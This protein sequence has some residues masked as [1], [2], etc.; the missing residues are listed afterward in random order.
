[1]LTVYNCITN[2]HDLRLVGLAAVI[3]ALA[4]F[5]AISLLWHVRRS[6]GPMRAVWLGVSATS[7]GF[8]IWATHFIAMLAFAPGLPE[9]Y[10]IPLT[11]LSLVAAIVLT[12]AG[13]AVA[14]A[15]T[16]T[17]GLLLG[18]AIVGG[19]I[20]AMHYTGM[21]AFE[22]QG[23]VVWDPGLVTASII[24][25]GLFGAAAL[26]TG[27]RG[28]SL[29]WKGL[30]A[31][32]L[33]LAICSHHFTAMGAA[34]IIP[35]PTIEF[36]KAAIPSG[37]LAIAV[38][39]ASFIVIMLALAGAALDMRD[40]R[41]GELEV[42]R[43]RGLANAVVE[44]LLVCE[45]ETIVTVNDNFA[46]LIGS[47][48]ESLVGAKLEQYI[49]EESTR[50]QLSDDPEQPIEGEMRHADGT[51]TPVE[52]IVRSIDFAGKTHQAIAV[53]DLRARKQA[54]QHI[55]YLAHHDALTGLVNRNTFNK[56]LDQE[57]ESAL[58]TG[59]RV[60]VLC[61]DLDRFKEV[62]DLFGHA[63]G[64][65]VLQ[66][67]AKRITGVLDDRH[68][69]ARLS[70]DE[71]AIVAPRLANPAA[72]GRIAED[73][74]ECLRAESQNP[75]AEALVST[76]IGVAICP[77]DATDRQTLLTHADTALYRAKKDGRATYRFF[78]AT[79]GAEV[80]DRR[81]LE[82][83]LRHAIARDELRLVYQPQK[84]IRT[85]TVIGFE[86]L[87]RWKHPTRG[88]VPPAVF[89]PIAEE[90][91]SILS[92]GEWVLRT[93]C[94]DAARWTN[95]LTVAVNV[96][97]T[98]IHNANFAHVVHEILFETGMTPGRLELEITE[99]AL[100]RDLTRALSTL[101]RIK[102]LGVRIAMDDF[103]TGYSSLSNLRAFPFDKIK[104]DGSFIKSVNAND[105]A[106]TIVRAVLG[107]GRGLGLP[108][109][110]EGVETSAELDFLRDALC[111]EAQGYLLGMPSDIACYHDLTHGTAS[112]TDEPVVVQLAQ[113]AASV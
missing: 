42:D 111:N 91:G 5:T 90:S 105:Q 96:S 30:G 97:A 51:R 13:L 108:V 12:G 73:I 109:L 6:H 81:L 83:D 112:T 64:D 93:A 44:G 19:G 46:R 4:S 59:H 110:A 49:P 74:L 17:A 28:D 33:T 76:S 41:R 113:K 92:I 36:S 55:R 10:N 106:A 61:L 102:M 104:I 78:E 15:W 47:T 80:R 67:V 58:A 45:G 98:Q 95:P 103:G 68:V 21:A 40:R 20:A 57:I 31:L 100:V 3:C 37:W 72:A 22:V 63:T 53:R 71:F 2:Q 27:L 86:A 89:I 62:N 26:P 9:A 75:E 1:M 29:K 69:M 48:A 50:L 79:M 54:E 38:A 16:S 107:L 56:K 65:K 85:G 39:L 8:G 52:L 70:G 32:L 87:L 88:E 94:R 14:M 18:G 66:T 25:G 77:D 7:T 101:R 82:H 34:S 99:T 24:L 23:H 11:F 60:A 35:D 43:M 84:D